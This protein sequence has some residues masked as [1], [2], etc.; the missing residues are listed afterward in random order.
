MHDALW[1]TA[2]SV[3]RQNSS[4]KQCNDTTLL[5]LQT[6]LAELSK[7]R[8][9]FSLVVDTPDFIAELHKDNDRVLFWSGFISGVLS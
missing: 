5:P 4:N 2:L 8:T 3:M 1:A 7:F 6:N 9:S